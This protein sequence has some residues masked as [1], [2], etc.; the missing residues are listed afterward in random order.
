MSLLVYTIYMQQN[1]YII[2]T[3]KIEYFLQKEKKVNFLPC[4]FINT[5]MYGNK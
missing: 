1:T 4:E 2:Y 5:I 3:L